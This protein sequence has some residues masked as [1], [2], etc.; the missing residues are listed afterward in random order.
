MKFN[1]VKKIQKMNKIRG[2][3][4]ED[5]SE[6]EW[7][8]LCSLFLEFEFEFNLRMYDV[9]EPPESRSGPDILKG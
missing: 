3:L 6:K 2:T 8:K 7:L 4:L 5:D 9:P 1:I